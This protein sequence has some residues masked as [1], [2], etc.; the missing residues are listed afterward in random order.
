M[1]SRALLGFGLVVIALSSPAFAQSSPWI[2]M[3]KVMTGEQLR[4]TGVEGLTTAQRN[5]LD[6]WLS[7]YT[8]RVVQLV[9]DSSKPANS[10]PSAYA[11]SSGDLRD[12][13]R[14]EIRLIA[15]RSEST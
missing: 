1:E 6:Q 14:W 11:G 9:Q 15:T 5:A 13:L 2:T 7:E 3:D 12:S 4:K 8:S 10:F